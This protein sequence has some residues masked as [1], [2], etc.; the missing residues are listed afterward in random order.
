MQGGADTR[1]M[2]TAPLF[3]AL[4]AAAAVYSAYRLGYRSGFDDG[5]DAGFQ[6][7]K[8]EGTKLGSLRGYAIGFDRGKRARPEPTEEVDVAPPAPAASNWRMGLLVLIVAIAMVFWLASN[9][10]LFLRHTSTGPTVTEVGGESEP[11]PAL[12]PENAGESRR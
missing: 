3:G 7:G 12:F 4:L 9:T 8:K 2:S 11:Y 10:Q 1:N 6:D 5:R